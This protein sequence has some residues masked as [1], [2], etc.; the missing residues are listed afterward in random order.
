[1][2][3][4][5]AIV[6]AFILEIGDIYDL[7]LS[8]R[9]IRRVRAIEDYSKVTL[10]V[11]GKDSI[12]RVAYREVAKPFDIEIVDGP[13]V[14]IQETSLAEDKIVRLTK[15]LDGYDFEANQGKV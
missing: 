15:E 6:R 3:G 7:L 9:Q 12:P 14:D 4:V 8:K 2:A 10:I 11:K 13:S 1:M 5:K